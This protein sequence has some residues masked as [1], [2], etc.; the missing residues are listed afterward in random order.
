MNARRLKNQFTAAYQQ[1]A[2]YVTI[3]HWFFFLKSAKFV[4]LGLSMVL[5][6]PSIVLAQSGAGSIQGTVTDSTGAAIPA[7]SI[8]VVN[9]AT[10]VSNDTKSNGVGFY[11]VPELFTGTYTVTVSAPGMS[12]YES[13]IQLLVAQ[14]AFVNPVLSTGAV[15][16]KITV[17]ADAVQ[18]TTTDSGTITSTL[19]NARINQLPMN[20][21]YLTQLLQMTTPGLENGGKDINGLMP[22]A[23]I[24][25][26]DGVT[27]QDN[28]RG[29]LFYASGGSQL[30]DPDS[31]QEVK[32]VAMNAGAEYATP[33]TAIF[34]TKSGTNSLHGTFFETARNNA[35]GIAKARQDPSN[36]VAPHL[37]RNEFGA[38]MGGPIVLPHIYHGKDRSFW[39]FAFERFSLAQSISS[40]GKVPTTAMSQGDFS[41]LVNSSGVKQ[42]IFDPSTTANS[43][44]C[45]YTGSANPYCRTPF[46][47]NQIPLGQISP[48]AKL[49]YQL[50][51]LPTSA[52]NPL[53][54]SN[55]TSVTPQLNL[56]PQ[57]TIRLD[58]EFNEKNRAF[59]RY[60]QNLQG[61]NVTSGPENRAADGIPVGAALSISGYANTPTNGY[62]AG[63]GYTHVFSPTFF[64]ETLV[65]QQWFSEKKLAG[66][67][68]LTPNVDYESMLNLPNNFGEKGFPLIGGQIFQLGSSQT[69]TAK[70]GQII[71]TIDENLSKTL[72]HHQMQFGGR[73]R[74]E[75]MVQ[76]PQQQPDKISFD[77]IPTAIYNTASGG[78]Y[79]ALPN[80]G[81]ADASL[82][83]GSAAS[84]QVWLQGG[85]NHY[86]DN[87][88]DAYFQDNYHVGKKVTLN[89][90][91]RY[92]AHPAIWTKYN[93]VEGFDFKTGAVVL[94][95]PISTLVSQ[96]RT[97]QSIITNDNNIGVNF[98]TPSEAGFPATTLMRNYNL[99]FL[100][101]VGIAYQPFG[102]TH[103]TVI[104]G[105]YGRFANPVPLEDFIEYETAYNNPFTN[106]YTQSYESSSQAIDGLPNE[107]LRYNA[108][109][110]FGVIGSN[111]ANAVNSNSTNGILPGLYQ[112]SASP[113]SPPQFITEAN[114]TVE[115][116]LKGNSALR[117]SWIYTHASNLPLIDL[118]NHAL[119]T[120][121]WE[122]A[123]GTTPPNGGLS[124]I[125]TPQQNTYS[126]TALRPYNNT[127]WG[128]NYLLTRTG[129]SND[130]AAQVTYERLFHHGVAY[131][132]SYV[133][134]RALRVGGDN[135]GSIPPYEYP[136]ADYP[137]VM[138]SLGT[139]TSPY[140]AVYSGVAP[141]ALPAGTPNWAD[142]HKMIGYQGYQ[143]DSSSTP[144]H[145]ITMNGIV[146]LPFGRGKRFLGNVNRF[147]N[148]LVGGFQ[149]A[150]NGSILSQAFQP[151]AGLNGAVAPVKVYKH[152][153]ATMDCRSGVCE[154]SYL[155]YNGYLAPTV[156]QGVT[157]ST[158]TKN[159]VTGLPS[160]Y[161]PMQVPVD[162]TPG[163][164]YYG[165]NDVVVTLANGKQT[166]VA[167]DAG[168]AAGNY[169]S[170]TWLNGPINYVVN[171]SVFKEF[172]ITERM[173]LRF[174]V[175]A[176]N[177]LN[178]QGYNNPDTSGL[179]HMLTSY[180]TPRQLQFTVRFTF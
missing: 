59:L 71:S 106:S 40:L 9:V 176:F 50:V 27:T 175:D 150:G 55:L 129:W 178:V 171:L 91:L 82:F 61:T 24:Y 20:G 58:H 163:T 179:E 146:D 65:N 96:G 170:K 81:N 122:L 64:A 104:R 90:G 165:T 35:I 95:V 174:N 125:G 13:S 98:E 41:G 89:L 119:T 147:E 107:V 37:V 177:A 160:D 43:T 172:P 153:Y 6:A 75:R 132:V 169:L 135:S 8:H 18:L 130:N 151:S 15:T 7:A 149:V 124:V 76:Y 92:E 168:P 161:V 38:S 36:L 167:Y 120:Y 101:R 2:T 19:E 113:D 145:H 79:T 166:T 141:P 17:S 118:Y 10:G 121:E 109:A 68:A 100:P 126:A 133:F 157:G 3:R 25:E 97:Q 152:R 73:F 123:T 87:E 114:F 47:N 42:V 154:K 23:V 102:G 39:F 80:T 63:I 77:T 148:E 21:R 44:N 4:G 46:M 110:V 16:E 60:T 34:T 33:A 84:Y 127:T 45:P 74:H 72:G 162:N 131:Q 53:V 22:S 105:A 57:F 51:P 164:T 159:C 31:V 11:Q 48:T 156:T 26:I 99:V 112:Y 116:S 66:A 134:S 136:D 155:W 30:I 52:A 86:H 108:P 128:E 85:W 88:V 111:T 14:N 70:E 158:C 93:V 12:T 94:P 144:I 142:Y 49:Y 5:C 137:G 139:M 32:M 54:T 78:N 29:G 180:N 67:A 103:S 143:L 62:Y 69:N 56:E 140:G 1:A 83:L 138:G 117:L 115:Q 28:L 173:N